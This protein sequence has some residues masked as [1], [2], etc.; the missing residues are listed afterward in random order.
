MERDAKCQYHIG[1]KRPLL[2]IWYW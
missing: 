2:P 1:N